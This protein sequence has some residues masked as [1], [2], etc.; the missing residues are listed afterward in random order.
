M[1]FDH[2]YYREHP[3]DGAAL[4]ALRKRSSEKWSTF[5][6]EILPMPVAEMDF[7]LAQPI[8]DVLIEMIKNSDTGYIGASKDLAQSF[9]DYSQTAWGWEVDPEQ[10]YICTDVGV[11]MIEVSRQ[12]V[13]PGDLI[14]IHT[15]LYFNMKTNWI[16]ELKCREYDVPLIKNGLHYTLDLAGIEA[17]YK[18][19]VKLHYLC[20]PHNPIG[21]VFSREELEQIAE[22]AKRYGVIVASDEIHAPLSFAEHPFT[23]FLAAS[24]TAKEVGICVTSASKS[25]N[26]AGLKCA[27]IVTAHPKMKALA[28][29][30]PFS[31]KFRASHLGARAAAVAYT[32][33]DWLDSAMQTLD[34]NRKAVALQL[35]AKLPEAGYRVPDCSYLAWIDLSAYN[36]GENP[37]ATLLERGKV[38]V[39]PGGVFGGNS[40]QFIRLNFATSLEVLT[41]GIDRIMASL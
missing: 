3:V 38:A 29:Q 11:G 34:R 26:L 23:P 25:W 27:Q 30:M 32:C 4:A 39:S 28:D 35:A 40:E 14:M 21:T 7:E 20:N 16:A 19:G 41:E 5:P 18:A 1:R 9:S 13:V 24:E 33:T 10:F 15:P 22:L 6:P 36:L 12:V 31:I 17:G 2:N 8:A 37:A